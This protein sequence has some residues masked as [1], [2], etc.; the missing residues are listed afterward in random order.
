MLPAKQQGALAFIGNYDPHTG[1][2]ADVTKANGHAAVTMRRLIAM[3]LISAKIPRFANPLG[4]TV[5]YY[6]LTP[7]GEARLKGGS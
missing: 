4:L 2:T 3:G 6:T 7:L 5:T 1:V